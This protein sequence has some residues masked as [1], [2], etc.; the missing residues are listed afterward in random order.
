M[1]ILDMAYSFGP[2]CSSNAKKIVMNYMQK[3][4]KNSVINNKY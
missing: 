1:M 3:S 2:P 4:I